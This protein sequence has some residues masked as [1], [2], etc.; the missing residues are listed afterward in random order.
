[1]VKQ[2]RGERDRGWMV[3]KGSAHTKLTLSFNCNNTIQDNTKRVEHLLMKVKAC[4]YAGA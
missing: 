2:K 1:M 4:R 3:H